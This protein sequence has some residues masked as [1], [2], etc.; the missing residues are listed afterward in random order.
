[1]SE[2]TPSTTHANDDVNPERRRALRYMLGWMAA[3]GID[4]P[5]IDAWMGQAHEA[6]S[7]A[8]SAAAPQ[9]KKKYRPLAEGNPV[10]FSTS[11][12]NALTRMVDL[13]IPRTATPGA[14]DAGVPLYIDII[15]RV[16]DAL[17]NKFR[18]GLAALDA[19][20]RSATGRLFVDAQAAE[21][22]K[23]LQAMQPAGAPGNEFFETVKS[24]TIVGYYSSEIG[25]FEELRFTGNK[26]LSAFP[27]CTHGG[28][29]LD[30]PARPR[31][32]AGTGTNPAQRWPFPSSDNIT[33]DDL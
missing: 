5:L 29:S 23:I 32:E 16:D 8:R 21:Q 20:S 4:P 24:M 17:G 13:I 9:Q 18:S 28:H 19:A 7:Q 6:T 12:Y 30:V 10:Y 31:R 11:E 22:V 25:L 3:V 33:G 15:L 1:M 27:G 14:A 26:I 2:F